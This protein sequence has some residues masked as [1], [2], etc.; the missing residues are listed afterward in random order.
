MNQK[1]ILIIED[2][3]SIRMALQEKLARENYV[4]VESADGKEGLAVAL[5]QHPDLILLDI[6]MPV[7]GGEEMLKELRLDPWGKDV[8][9]ILLTNL[10]YLK[11]PESK[12]RA[13]AYMLKASTKLE[14]VV[15]MIQM[16]A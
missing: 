2:D 16:Y 4:V 9:V 12:N 11:D 1:T 13:T 7:M 3:T 14:D 5:S 6:V 15:Q 8:P 10:S